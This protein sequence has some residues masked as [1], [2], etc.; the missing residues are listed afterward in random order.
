MAGI[1]RVIREVT[2]NDETLAI[3]VIGNV[4]PGGSFLTNP[5]TFKHFRDELWIPD[6]IE[7]RNWDM[8]EKDGA[9][10]IFEIAEKK[11]FEILDSISD[12]IL[13]DDAESAIDQVVIDAQ[14]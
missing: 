14:K 1:K 5:H 8:W 12:K 7:R 6:L 10:S 2:I 11:V 9:L 4:G 3:D 13:T